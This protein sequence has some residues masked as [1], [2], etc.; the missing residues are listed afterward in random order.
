MID[1]NVQIDLLKKSQYCFRCQKDSHC[2]L[3]VCVH[4]RVSKSIRTFKSGN[5]SHVYFSYVGLFLITND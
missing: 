4:D 3:D 1:I 5:E 2:S